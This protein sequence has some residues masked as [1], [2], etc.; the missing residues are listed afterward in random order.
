[1]LA[2][3]EA[4]LALYKLL[5]AAAAEAVAA[6]AETDAALAPAPTAR[7]P[8]LYDALAP[9]ALAR[10]ARLLALYEALN[11]CALNFLLAL[12]EAEAAADVAVYEAL[13]A[14]ALALYDALAVF[15]EAR[16]RRV[17][18]LAILRLSASARGATRRYAAVAALLQLAEAW[19]SVCVTL[20]WRCSA[21]R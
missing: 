8:A 19:A 4:L 10:T 11:A 5:A 1:M 21:R 20:L 13:I 3:Y 17:V 6:A 18:T 7:L 9:A 15:K 16:A 12:Y 14:C 2:L